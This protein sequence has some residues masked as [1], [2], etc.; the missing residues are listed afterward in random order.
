MAALAPPRDAERTP[1][2][3]DDASAA[4]RI[5]ATVGYDG[6][7]FEGWQTQP[8]GRTVQDTLEARLK[9][10]LK[11]QT[12]I[13]GSGR[14]DSGVHARAQTFHFDLPDGPLKALRLDADATAAAA[15]AALE[16]Y[17][18]G[19][20]KNCAL[21]PSVQLTSMRAAPPGFH[22]RSS[23]T[24]KRYVYSVCEGLGTPA[25]SRYAW[26][27]G[28]SKT[29]DVERMRAAAE[30]LV[31]QHDFSTYG[32]R[33]AGDPRDPVKT[34]RS[35]EVHR[36]PPPPEGFPLAAGDGRV[37]ITA[38]CDRYLRHMM[39]LV[40]GTLV[41]VGL[42]KLAPEDVGDLLAAR[43]RPATGPAPFMAPACGLCL[44]RCF[45]GDEGFV[46]GTRA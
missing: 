33:E 1:Y 28:R 45:Y 46:A 11:V 18:C 6:T 17:L 34:M 8:N 27:L 39:R 14:T 9:S 2:T 12:A 29:L 21:P 40:A 23:C 41:M 44:E 31:G 20:P 10:L 37:T 42:G 43:A 25:A 35:L 32:L 26:A 15:A 36:W 22:A 5:V 19:L 13:A 24:S 7:D 38:H 30:A 3:R 16:R 4:R